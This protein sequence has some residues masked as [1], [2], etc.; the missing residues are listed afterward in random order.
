MRLLGVLLLFTAG[1]ALQGCRNDEQNRVI[2][3]ESGK[4]QGKPDQQL[5]DAQ[6][7]RLRQRAK[8]GQLY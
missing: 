5:S 8:L 1:I 6:L 4:Y 7:E 2:F 3:Y